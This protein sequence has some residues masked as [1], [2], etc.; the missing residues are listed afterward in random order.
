[1]SLPPEHLDYAHRGYG[2]DQSWYEWSILPKRPPIK[3]P[4]G[5][6]IALWVSTAIEFFPLNP[7]AEPFK[8]PGSMS[9]PY[10]DLRHYTLRDYGNRVGIFRIMKVLEKFAITPT[11]AVNSAVAKRYPRLIE[12]V[13][14]RDWEV[15]AGG[16][17]MGHIHH[18]GLDEK[19]EAGWVAECVETLRAATGQPVKGWLSPARSQSM[20]TMDFVAGQGIDYICDWINDEMPYPITT[21]NGKL[22]AMPHSHEINDLTIILQYKR[23]EEEFTQ[24][25]IDQFEVLYREA[26]AENGRIMSLT[27]HPWIIGQPHRIKALETALAHIVAKEGVWVATG[28][29]ILEAW[30]GNQASA[31]G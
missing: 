19:E 12:E 2:M 1:M 26:S 27:I 6:K 31:T 5:A 13:V 8:A 23:S 20:H 29:E 28:A 18:G 11:V 9:T 10:P 14:K 15:I 21:A 7:P 17:D 3:W 25:L 16:V 30:L 22:T 4:G 24:H